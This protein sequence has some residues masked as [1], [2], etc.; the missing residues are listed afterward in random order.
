MDT[1]MG[2]SKGSPESPQNRMVNGE[3]KEGWASLSGQV[4]NNHRI[5]EIV[6]AVASSPSPFLPSFLFTFK[7]IYCICLYV[8]VHECHSRSLRTTFGELVLSFHL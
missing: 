1:S 8:E 6:S 5:T 4:I 3:S 2:E 7:R